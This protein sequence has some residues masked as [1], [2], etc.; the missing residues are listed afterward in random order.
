[1][2]GVLCNLFIFFAQL[3]ELQFL[4]EHI[5]CKV[6]LI[7]N[8]FEILLLE[9]SG[10]KSSPN[11]L[12]HLVTPAAHCV[13][14]ACAH[15][16]ALALVRWLSNG[17]YYHP[18]VV[19][20]YLWF[21]QMHSKGIPTLNSHVRCGVLLESPWLELFLTKFHNQLWMEELCGFFKLFEDVLHK[22]LGGKFVSWAFLWEQFT[23]QHWS[24]QLP[25]EKME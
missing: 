19:V 7:V 20:R 6:G 21:I 23:Q 16:A 5:Q 3:S 8:L 11:S 18:H 9:I 15:W 24:N 13:A 2:P 17:R 4:K 14:T 22:N 25:E 1:M 12:E 10:S